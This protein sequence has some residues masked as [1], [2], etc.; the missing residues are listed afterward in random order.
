MKYTKLGNTGVDVSRL[1]LGC[2]TYGEPDAGAHPWT[3]NE[4]DARPLFRHAVEQGINFFDTANSYSAGTSEIIVGKLLKEFTR[5]E[6]VVLA[7]KIYFSPGAQ[8]SGAAPNQKGLS[9]KSIMTEINASLKRLGTDYVDLYQIHRWDYSTPVE[10]TMEALNDVVKSGKALYI[11][12]SSMY[13]WQFA[14]AQHIAKE[15]GWSQFVTMQN[16][17]NLLYRE[18]EREMIPLCEDLGVG[19]MPWSPLARGR[20]AR[21]RGEITARTETDDFG[22]KIF[23][24][25]EDAD[26]KI[27]DAVSSLAKKRGVSM[28]QIALAWVLAKKQVS[29]PILG[30][31]KTGQIDDAVS[32]LSVELSAAEILELEKDYVPHAVTGHN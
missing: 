15:N 4:V 26:G 29:S 6:E 28:A 21:P 19:L 12:A 1:C 10:E 17:V 5:R 3:L 32:A 25:T 18:E 20:L 2:M 27:I 23:E 7:T 24:N 22:K 30:A 14:K 31:S 8:G 9:R 13:A 16:Y 11:G